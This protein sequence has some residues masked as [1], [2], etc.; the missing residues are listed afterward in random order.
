[1]L[2]QSSRC[3]RKVPLQPGEGHDGLRGRLRPRKA[4]EEESKGRP[5]GQP[6]GIEAGAGVRL[7]VCG[8]GAEELRQ[9]TDGRRRN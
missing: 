7:C 2:V 5:V 3:R 1:M 6:A 9:G 4:W 8:R